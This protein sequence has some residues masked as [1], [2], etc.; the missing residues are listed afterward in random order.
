MRGA[1]ARA[2]SWCRSTSRTDHG[3]TA[4]WSRRGV[5]TLS[6]A[7]RHGQIEQYQLQ[8]ATGAC[9]DEAVRAEDT[10]WSRIAALYGLLEKITGS[11]VVTLNRAVA[12]AMV[13]GPEVGLAMVANLDEPQRGRHRLAAVRAH[14]SERAGALDTALTHYRDA[15][16]RTTSLAERD[17]LLLRAARLAAGAR[18]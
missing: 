10:D 6:S 12:V 15:A 18:R 9:H 16:A 5:R 7:L 8:A 1:P 11:P 4:C 13:D 3:G 17:H 2:A 14:L